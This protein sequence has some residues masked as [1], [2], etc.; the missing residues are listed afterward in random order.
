[1]TDS[2][3]DIS[4][5][6]ADTLGITV[7]P[8]YIRFGNEVYR[9]GV[10]IGSA[11][12]YD[13]LSKTRVHPTTSEPTPEDFARVYSECSKEAEAII[14]IHISGRMSR[15][16]DSANEAKKLAKAPSR[17]EVID[18][19]LAS[20][21]LAL[22]VMFA[23]NL[24]KA[25]DTF[26]TYSAAGQEATGV[27]QWPN[28]QYDD[29]VGGLTNMG[30]NK[31]AVLWWYIE[32]DDHIVM[33]YGRDQYVTEGQA[34]DELPPADSLP[35]RISAASVLATKFIFQKSEDIAVKIESAFG[36][37]FTS[38]GVTDHSNLANLAWSVA[39]HTMDTT[40]DMGT[41]A[42]SNITHSTGAWVSSTT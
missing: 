40:L 29:S 18:S 32:P 28:E 39:G 11:E 30:N 20:V 27:A 25:G 15:I 13:K 4:P 41:N 5:E 22:A 35:N 42:I 6:V 21:G 2:T 26:E 16:F 3:S 31:W 19:R 38:S 34:E 23:A 24:V 37:P 14:S 10:D 1:M 17:I 33:I 8:G 12:L 7:V 9:D 36:T